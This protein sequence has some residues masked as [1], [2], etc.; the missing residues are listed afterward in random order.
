MHCSAV[1]HKVHRH[2]QHTGKNN[3]RISNLRPQSLKPDCSRFCRAVNRLHQHQHQH[4]NRPVGREAPTRRPPS[5]SGTMHVRRTQPSWVHH[6]LRSQGIRVP[7]EAADATMDSASC[8]ICHALSFLPQKSENFVFLVA[9]TN[10]QQNC[11]IFD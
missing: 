5:S 4:Q 6:Q 10:Y 7:V 3:Q 11:K 8:K 2:L 1:L 9:I